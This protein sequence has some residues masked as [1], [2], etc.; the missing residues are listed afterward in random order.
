VL[1]AVP[2]ARGYA[3]TDEATLVSVTLADTSPVETRLV[4]TFSG[5]PPPVSISG[6]DSA[7]PVLTLGRTGRAPGANSPSFVR[8][9]LRDLA[10]EQRGGDLAL[11]LSA[12]GAMHV[13]ATPVS[14]QTLFVAIRSADGRQ[15]TLPGPTRPP[16]SGA[17]RSSAPVSL[18]IFRDPRSEDEEF[19]VVP[20]KYADV[21]EIVGLLSDGPAQ[22]PNDTFIPQEP[23]FGSSG[24]TGGASASN[25]QNLALLN[26]EALPIG[27]QVDEAIGIDRRLNAVILRGPPE[28][29][30]R[31]RDRI[32]LLDV[33]V[34]SVLLETVFVELTE[35]GARNVGID[36]KNS[37]GKIGVVTVNT[38]A[39]TPG[40][41]I[42]GS[43][44]SNAGQTSLA[45]QAAI[46][47]QVSKGE[48]RII[49]RPR[50]SAQSGSSAKIITGDALPILTSIALSGVNAVSQQVQ[51]VNVG[52]TLQIA[53]RVSDD[54]YV[55][56]HVFCEVSS[57]TGYSQGYPTI[58]Q[59]EAST[60]A[61]VMDGDYFV[62]GG[63]TQEN[64]LTTRE[65][66]PVLGQIPLVGEL[67]KLHLANA[68]RTQLYIVVT[69]HIAR[70]ADTAAARAL[71][72]K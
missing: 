68:S 35:T 14:G 12:A 33:P 26:Q 20:L 54:G 30:R 60:T 58:S 6:N 18:A 28:R 45:L 38:G 29:I 71:T 72:E 52:V 11:S 19:A 49:S 4:L 41:G 61:T 63:L 40:G 46:F 32:A 69:P 8:G 62:I 64:R 23:A 51:Y 50:I 9:Y 10:F 47:A 17:A 42:G 24:I 15:T 13:E 67:F 21:S 56:S 44:L 1:L 70:P 2:V 5:P 16:A 66:T 57:V 34:N 65:T 36:F 39:F 7:R 3:Q 59:R 31:L 48:G 27:T 55:T 25:Q 53:P 37:A 43:G 22:K